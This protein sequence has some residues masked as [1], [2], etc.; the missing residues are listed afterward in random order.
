MRKR[1]GGWKGEACEERLGGDGPFDVTLLRLLQNYLPSDA[2]QSRKGNN[3]SGC[4]RAV[5]EAYKQ[6]G[7][8]A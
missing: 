1:A 2:A 3:P 4:C 7:G 5:I 6:T 8:R